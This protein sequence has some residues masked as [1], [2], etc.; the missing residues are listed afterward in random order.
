MNRTL[1]YQTKFKIIIFILIWLL[2]Y[3]TL[4]NSLGLQNATLLDIPTNYSYFLIEHDKDQ[5]LFKARTSLATS[6]DHRR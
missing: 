1:S 5:N 4:N 3:K 6:Q 2:I